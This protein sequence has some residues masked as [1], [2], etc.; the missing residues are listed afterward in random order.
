MSIIKDLGDNLILR[1]ANTTDIE[2]LAAL[3]GEMHKNFGDTE[4]DQGLIVWTR[5]LMDGNHPTTGASDVLVV[6]DTNKNALVS[7]TM[8][9]SQE[10]A[11]EGIPFKVGMPELVAT[12]PEYRNKGLV[13]EQFNVLHQWSKER[14]QLVQ[15]IGGI[16]YY[17][18]QFGYEL[19]V[20]FPSRRV[21]YKTHIVPLKNGE[22][23]A[24]IIRE[25]TEADIPLIARLYNEAMKRYELSVV[26]DEAAWRYDMFSVSP[27]S[28][29]KK[30]F[31][32]IETPEGKPV[33]ALIHHT[34]LWSGALDVSFYELL[35]GVRWTAVSPSVLRYI[36]KRGEEYA[37]RDKKE[38]FGAFLFELG[39]SHPAY[40]MLAAKLPRKAPT[41]PYY[42]RVPDLPAFINHIAPALEA[43]LD[44]SPYKLH[45]GEIKINLFRT[46]F[47]I[48]LN[49]GKITSEPYTQAHQDDGDAFF[50][51]LTF[52]HILF[53]HLELEDIEK[54]Y[55]D[56]W[57]ANDEARTILKTI[58]PKKDSLIT[59]IA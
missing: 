50:P 33:G 45:T 20:N 15:A 48:V 27:G 35:P 17:Y 18:R 40:P 22:T 30:Q 8:L 44:V 4:P 47:K 52:L 54:V 5:D 11:Y 32:V 14:N 19:T 26:R 6:E 23:E 57:I 28:W 37:A 56:C 42:M 58:F 10:W 49:E 43:R 12:R 29:R 46:A 3:N 39:D 16:R 25:A 9:I 41:Y 21:G 2:G 13:R 51:N 24:Y 1:R 55:A 31:C 53:G 38:E 34:K 59:V 36:G 7:T